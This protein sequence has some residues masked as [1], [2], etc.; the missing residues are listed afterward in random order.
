M[1]KLLLLLA[2]LSMCGC[3]SLGG[4]G[5]SDAPAAD[6]PPQESPALMES[7]REAAAV[8]WIAHLERVQTTADEYVARLAGVLVALHGAPAHLPATEP[9]L[10]E[11][12]DR[13]EAE[14]AKFSEARDVDKNERVQAAGAPVAATGPHY[15][16][17]ALYG[18]GVLLIALG[19]FWGFAIGKKLT[20]AFIGLAGL[21]VFCVGWV[22]ERYPWAP[23]AVVGIAVLVGLWLLYDAWRDRKAAQAAAATLGT[24]VKS[25]QAG[26][27]TLPA[28]AAKLMGDVMEA[29]QVR[30]SSVEAAVKAAKGA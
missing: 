3:F 2:V 13:A 17:L 15:G 1:R 12:A 25:V 26:K 9:E 29:V 24:V 21:G 7:A 22:L 14:V 10:A 19:V 23:L 6:L 8:S 4:Y 30:G 27:A 18:G 16:L 28:D 5:V 20:G 11:A